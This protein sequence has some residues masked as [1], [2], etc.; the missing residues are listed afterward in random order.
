MDATG[1]PPL[2]GLKVIDLTRH[3]SGPYA[4]VSLG[5]FGADVIKVEPH[6]GGDASRS[7]GVRVQGKISASFLMWNRSKRSIALDLYTDEAKD[8]IRRLA[9]EADVFV[10][11]FRPGVIAKMGLDYETLAAIN[12]RL[13]YVSLSAFGEGPL[14]PFPGTDPVVQAMSGVMSV[15]GEVGGPPLL[16]GVPVADFTA[17]M[18]T[19]QGVLL[20]LLAREKTGRGQK[21]E[22]SML[23]ALLSSL[24]TR[25]ASFWATG[26]EPTRNGGA[27]SVVMPYQVWRTADGYAVAGVWNGGNVMWPRF[28][29][30]LGAP[31]LAEEADFATNEL[32]LAHKARLEELLSAKFITRTT[33]EWEQR[34]NALGVLFSPVN[35]FPQI[36]NHPHVAQ[37]D[38][39][40]SLVHPELGELPQIT[41]PIKLSDT[42]ARLNRHP[43]ALGEH[44]REI[45]GELGLDAGAID[46]LVAAG[47]AAG[48]A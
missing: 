38:I 2:H 31:E 28:C 44:T 41:P 9:A 20:A 30:A 32:R 45:L 4:T 48:A 5:D 47:I 1:Q 18:I 19:V 10:E 17:A 3:M 23:H 24:T 16:V 14:G 36:L 26:R 43:P 40:G 46:N 37:A 8:I 22:I 15:T 7:T 34:F 12:P 21:V 6:K 25:L 27:H 39:L 11:N 33:A 29:D 42:P 35:T 13:I